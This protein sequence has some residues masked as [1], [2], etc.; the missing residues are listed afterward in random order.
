MVIFWLLCCQFSC[1]FW[2]T[3]GTQYFEMCVHI[4]CS[5]ESSVMFCRIRCEEC[6]SSFVWIEY[7]FVWIFQAWM[8]C[9][10]GCIMCIY[11]M[12]VSVWCSGRCMYV[13]SLNIEDCEWTLFLNWHCIDVGFWKLCKLCVPWW[14]FRFS[15]CVR[16]VGVCM[17]W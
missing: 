10:H 1:M 12:Y 17:C 6:T 5:I 4:L 9:R 15:D 7:K 16:Y 14:C 8:L 2:V 13:W 3:G 11:C